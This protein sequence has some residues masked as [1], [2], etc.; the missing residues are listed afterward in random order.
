MSTYKEFSSEIGCYLLF[1]RLMSGVAL[2]TR[3]PG[4]CEKITRSAAL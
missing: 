4:A 3:A 2:L 1:I